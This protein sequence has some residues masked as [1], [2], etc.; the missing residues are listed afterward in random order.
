M[1]K[2]DWPTDEKEPFPK[3]F[4]IMYAVG[5][6]LMDFN[7]VIDTFAVTVGVNSQMHLYHVIEVRPKSPTRFPHIRVRS[8]SLLNGE[9]VMAKI[10]SS[11]LTEMAIHA[12]F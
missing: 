11:A 6:A 2:V 3:I 12:G 1:N 5:Y 7:L 4:K 8:T 9:S 10:S